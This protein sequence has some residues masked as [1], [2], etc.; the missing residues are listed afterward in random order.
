MKSTVYVSRKWKNPII[1][2][3][4]TIGEVGSN[5][6]LDAFLE[7][8]V[9]EIGNPTLMFTKATLLQKLRDASEKIKVEMKEGTRYL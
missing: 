1:N 8:L 3:F 5:M 2:S 4:M 7:T 6:D 9:E